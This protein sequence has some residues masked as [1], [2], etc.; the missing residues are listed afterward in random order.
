[1]KRNALVLFGGNST[2]HDISVITAVEALHAMPIKGYQVIPVY[3]RDG[4]WYMGSRLF[5]IKFYIDFDSKGLAS[6][7]LA[8]GKLYK[9]NHNRRFAEFC[10]VDCAVL[11]THGGDGENG[12]LQGLLELNGIPYTSCDVRASALC[13]EKHLTKL[14]LNA[15]GVN[16]VEGREVKLPHCD[17]IVKEI[18]DEFGYPVMIKPCEQ[19]SSI[20]LTFAK[21]RTMLEEGLAVAASFGKRALV[22]KGLSDF[23]ELNVAV[24][25]LHGE[26]KVSEVER[27]LSANDFL[28][29][30]DKYMNGAKGMNDLKREFPAKIPQ[31][32]AEFLKCTAKTVYEHL[33]LFGVVRMDFLQKDKL[34]LNEINTLPGSLAHYLYPEYSYTEFLKGLIE[35]AII[36]GAGKKAEYKTDVLKQLKGTM[37]K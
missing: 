15:M 4:G 1:M 26:I 18:E 27:P 29:Y 10:E 7:C 25:T 24:A 23:V 34:Y 36:R 2:E 33:G 37:K 17:A 20:G 11:A 32:T 8:N 30:A 14:A 31:E 13:M 6:V 16:T 21:T 9:K 19:G 35:S 22:E 12:S 3:I 28:T 5:D